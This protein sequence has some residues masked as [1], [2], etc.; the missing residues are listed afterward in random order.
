MVRFQDFEV[1]SP[2]VAWVCLVSQ[3]T[4]GGLGYA[5]SDGGRT[6]RQMTLPSSGTADGKFGVQVVDGMHGMLQLGHGLYATSDGGRGWRAVPLPPGEHFGPGAHFLSASVGWYLDL[7]VDPGRTQQPTAM[8]WTSDGGASWS[9]LWR[10]DARHLESRGVPLDGSKYVLG[11]RDATTGW[12]GVSQAGFSRLLVT[13]DGGHSWSPV[14]LPLHEPAALIDLQLLPGGAAVLLART[15]TARL[16][17]PSR[18]GGRTWEEGRPVPIIAPSPGRSD[19]RVSFTDHD[20]WAVADGARLRVTSDAG[21][22]WRDVP[23]S[24]P[25]GI[26][27]LHDLWLTADRQGWATADDAAGDVRVLHTTDAGAHWSLSHVPYLTS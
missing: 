15:P 6:W 12:M 19:D 13:A 17:V 16:A 8:W 1:A 21:L 26:S 5:T 10:V 11:F 22:T 24:L 7:E 14:S 3:P 23:T 27:T 4:G 2:T 20:H 25:A 9:E 18:D